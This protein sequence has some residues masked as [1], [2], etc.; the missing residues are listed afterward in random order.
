MS[1]PPHHPPLHSFSCVRHSAGGIA[2]KEQR[3]HYYDFPCYSHLRLAFYTLSLL[4]VCF[5]FTRSAGHPVG[6]K[7]TN[8]S[9]LL[10]PHGRMRKI[11]VICD[12]MSVVYTQTDIPAASCSGREEDSV[13]G[14]K[15]RGP[16]TT[17]PVS[18][19]G[20]KIKELPDV[21]TV[22]SIHL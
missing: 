18:G 14:E 17:R 20:Y 19:R 6:A 7:P 12:A 4:F 5:F 8:R 1:L 21:H 13:K 11:L 16:R 15:V 10:F 22:Y 2:A 9:V 3:K